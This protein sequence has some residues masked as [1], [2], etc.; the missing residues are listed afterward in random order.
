M[1]A[2]FS[3]IGGMTEQ[4]AIARAIELAGSQTALADRIGATKQQVN[5]WATGLMRVPPIRCRAIE[6]AT[7]VSVHLLRPDVFGPAPHEAAE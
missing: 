2:N 4:D 1:L 5:H 6:Q 7:G 3:Y